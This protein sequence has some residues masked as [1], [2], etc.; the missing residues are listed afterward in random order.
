METSEPIQYI[1]VDRRYCAKC[2]YS[3]RRGYKFCNYHRGVLTYI[4]TVSE[5][6]RYY[7]EDL[8][9][10]RLYANPNFKNPED[11]YLVKWER[12]VEKPNKENAEIV[13]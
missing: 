6:C 5:S 13:E 1:R 8:I 11:I 7:P 3:N 12:I 2:L 10:A 4:L 9:E